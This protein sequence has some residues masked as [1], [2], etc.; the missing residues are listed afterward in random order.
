MTDVDQHEIERHGV[1]SMVIEADKVKEMI[2]AQ[3]IK[4]DRRRHQ[5]LEK[6]SRF[7]L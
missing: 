7:H 2:G 4:H 3:N 1:N 6:A 5:D